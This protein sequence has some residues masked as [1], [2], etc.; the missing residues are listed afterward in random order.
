MNQFNE[1]GF[2]NALTVSTSHIHYNLF[3]YHS[4][5]YSEK[6]I[7][8]FLLYFQDK[9]VIVIHMAE[10]IAHN[11]NPCVCFLREMTSGRPLS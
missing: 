7:I 6:P 4:E 11:G 2:F 10:H 9:C 3:I 8:S 5:L 1:N